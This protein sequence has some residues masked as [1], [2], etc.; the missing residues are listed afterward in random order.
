MPARFAGDDSGS[1]EKESQRVYAILLA[2]EDRSV[3]GDSAKAPAGRR[4]AKAAAGAALALPRSPKGDGKVTGGIGAD[5]AGFYP[6]HAVGPHRRGL[7]P[8]SGASPSKDARAASHF[9]NLGPISSSARASGISDPARIHSVSKPTQDALSFKR[10]LDERSSSGRPAARIRAPKTPETSPTIHPDGEGGNATLSSRASATLSQPTKASRPTR[11]SPAAEPVP[12]PP[13]HARKMALIQNCGIIEFLVWSSVMNI[14]VR[15][16][17]PLLGALLAL[18][19]SAASLPPPEAASAA[20]SSDSRPTVIALVR[21]G[22]KPEAGLGMI[23]CQGL[24]RALA[25]PPVLSRLVGPPDSAIAPNPGSTKKDRGTAYSYNRPL[26]TLAPSA[27][28]AGIPVDATIAWN[29]AGALAA[30]L[31]SPRHEGKTVYVAWEHHLA[32][33]AVRELFS[34]LGSDPAALPAKWADD[35]FDSV[36]VITIERRAGKRQARFE[37]ADQNLAGL[38]TACPIPR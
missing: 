11:S 3:D 27:V 22:E 10:A 25:L 17:L 5:M 4:V 26:L 9:A 18:A 19:S 23:N 29:D 15:P 6:K 8:R 35:D 16:A 12:S 14:P 24:N 36:Y 2:R 20:P 37:R 38:P 31:A 33:V 30:E 7:D 13:P 32:L 28:A 34:R 1:A 21:H